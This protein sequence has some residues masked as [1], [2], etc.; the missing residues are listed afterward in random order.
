M[1]SRRLALVVVMTLAVQ[2]LV[3]AYYYEDLLFLRQAVDVVASAPDEVFREHA[4]AAL[5]RTRLTRRHL[6]T[7]AAAA[8]RQHSVDIEVQALQR[9]ALE[10]RQD[11]SMRLRLAD[12][13][14]RAGRLAE[15]EA[16]YLELLDRSE[17]TTP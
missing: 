5:K 13:L 3:F 4:L 7:I 10:Y 17:R 11:A 9:L 15:A 12:G 14:R 1:T 8:Q 16:I 2:G 6:E